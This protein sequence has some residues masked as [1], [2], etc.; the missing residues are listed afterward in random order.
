M[1]SSTEDLRVELGYLRD[2]VV[3]AA[4]QHKTGIVESGLKTYEALV[5]TFINV[6]KEF[7]SAYTREQALAEIHSIGGGWSEIE[8]IR[9]DYRE[10]ADAALA[11]QNINVLV[12]VLR[13]PMRLSQLAYRER[14]YFIFVQFLNWL[15]YLYD[16]AFNVLR[17]GEA[18]TEEPASEESL[19]HNVRD[20]LTLY[21]HDL[22]DLRI[23]HEINES[24]DTEAIE[25]S[26][27]FSRWV[28]VVFN[29]LLKD[30]YDKRRVEDFQ[31]FASE[32]FDIYDRAVNEYL[33][34]SP[35]VESANDAGGEKPQ[36][37]SPDAARKACYQGLSRLRRIIFLGLEAW[38]LR[39]YTTD[40]LPLEQARAFRD[41]T[42][43]PSDIPDLWRLYLEARQDRYEE[44]LDWR[45]WESHEHPRRGAYSGMAFDLLVLTPIL[46]RMLTAASMDRE[47]IQAL[48]LDLTPELFYLVG[49]GSGPLI[50][51]LNEV[52]DSAALRELAPFNSD[53]VGWLRERFLALAREQASHEE[54]RV[55]EASLSPE[56]VEE[57]K[58]NV[59]KGWHESSYL[60]KLVQHRGSYELAGEPPPG[61][62][63]LSVHL[64]E[65]KDI[66]VG[67]SRFSTHS[68]GSEWGRSLAQG[69][70]ELVVRQI[71]SVVPSLS[72][73]AVDPATVARYLDQALDAIG[74]DE[75]FVLLVGSLRASWA[76]ADSGRFRYSHRGSFGEEHE[77]EPNPSGYFDDIPVY[78]I[79]S[80]ETALALV[81]DLR[82][83]GRWQ[84]YRPRE[85]PLSEHLE[86]VIL[87]ELET[88]DEAKAQELLSEQPDTFRYEALDTGRQR[89]RSMEERITQVLQNVRV[90]VLEQLRFDVT[91][92][93]AGR[94]IRFTE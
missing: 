5:A 29:R 10:I 32:F 56:R 8:W 12:P 49:D 74:I 36:P 30:A 82:E 45:W 34:A 3:E 23:G 18:R 26:C 84:Q 93:D 81:A 92:P 48:Q 55:I 77:G 14:D 75:P 60:R 58:R 33:Y 2:N 54:R 57:L 90:L 44:E 51:S 19:F 83:L 16:Q 9:E 88:Y 91:N 87:F 61:L 6:L 78:E 20:R 25:T 11:A 62:G 1:S 64:W 22:A 72:P 65:R 27:E 47:Q 46:L 24:T 21:L 50:S 73:D 40:K 7:D 76:L 52:A 42:F 15:P 59:L 67:G 13:F 35:W 43:L 85:T 38:L 68:W 79:H 70:D 39:D 89:E 37:L 53:A 63:S 80:N 41:S 31:H 66:F 86:D 94:V 69:E 28:F 71:A 17:P 4:S